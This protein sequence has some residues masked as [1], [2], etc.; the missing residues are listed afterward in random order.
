MPSDKTL[1]DKMFRSSSHQVHHRDHGQGGAQ[2]RLTYH[3]HGNVRQRRARQN[4]CDLLGR[5]DEPRDVRD[6]A[7]QYWR[8]DCALGC[9]QRWQHEHSPTSQIE[10][11]EER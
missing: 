7:M 8:C 9:R 5:D 11:R 4:D 1:N 3:C 10:P 6:Y 2:P